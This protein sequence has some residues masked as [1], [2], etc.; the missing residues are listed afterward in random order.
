MSVERGTVNTSGGGGASGTVGNP[1]PATATP[2]AGKD[3]SNN[4]KELHT[5]ADGTL[6]VQPA[7]SV[8]HDGAA[9]A[10]N[11]LLQGAFA[12]AAA[13]ADVSADNDAVRLWALRNGSQVVN[14]AAAGALIGATANAL[15]VNIKSGAGSGGT[16]IADNAAFTQGTTN[17]TPAAGVYNTAYANRTSGSAAA[18]RMAIDGALHTNPVAAVSGGTSSKHFVAA[19]T[20]NATSLKASPGQVY[21]VNIF[22]AA[23]Y[24]IYLKF[25]D[26]A[27][28]PTVGTDPIVRTVACQAG[29]STVVPFDR[30]MVFATGIAYACIKDITDAG[31]TVLVANDCVVGIDYK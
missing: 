2:L 12:S 16:A 27:S 31:T 15:D 5:A 19:A 24:P 6:L 11:P 23:A 8:A 14:I 17:T 3:P 26:K 22:N 1:F 10:V 25:Y 30:G 9:A 4:L 20:T 28:A 18:L 29:Q 21:G 7:G 13:P